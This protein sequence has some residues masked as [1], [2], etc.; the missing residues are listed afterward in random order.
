MPLELAAKILTS[1]AFAALTLVIYLIA[2]QLTKNR[3]AALLAAFFS[4]FVP[5]L[6]TTIYQVSIY[7]VSLPLIFFL[8]YAFLRIEEKGFATLSIILT[9][10][11]LLTNASILMLLISCLLYLFVIRLEKQDLSKKEVEITLFLFFLAIWFNLIL[12]KKAFFLHGIR[13]IWQN[14]PTP[15]LSSYFRDISF[16]GIIYV[17]GVIPLLLGVYAVYQVFFKTKSKGTTLFISFAIISFIMLWLKLIPFETG[18]LFLSMSLI[19]LSAYTIKVM[20]V[21]TSKTKMAALP[22]IITVLLV[23][24]FI[25]TSFMP[26]VGV[27]KA[28]VPPQEDIVA[29]EWIGNNTEKDAVVLGRIEEGF[30]INYV[31]ERKNIADMNFL[32]IKNINQVYNDINSLYTLKLKSEAVRLINDYKIN[33][34]LLS[35]QSM[36]EYN[37]T[38]LFYA[39]PDCFE[40]VYDEEAIV[41]KFLGC[42]IK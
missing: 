39:E 9:I 41:Y 21:S 27:L 19:I 28:N 5:I 17:V 20:L 25:I 33:Y 14:I 18:L 38:R 34:I 11:I 23:L 36:K 42:D 1:L 30:L 8:G 12:Y 37:I 4:G 10:I 15:L 29:L 40:R 26:F 13:F 16:L 31:S 2:K 22:I 3:I 6:Y 32:L 35:V 24:F 7:S